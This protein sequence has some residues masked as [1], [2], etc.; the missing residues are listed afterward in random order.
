M[1]GAPLGLVGAEEAVAAAD[2]VDADAG[3][4]FGEPPPVDADEPVAGAEEADGGAL[5]APLPSAVALV[6]FAGFCPVLMRGGPSS[7][8]TIEGLD[9]ARASVMRSGGGGAGRTAGA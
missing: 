6:P 4:L 7:G 5:A 1:L 9:L 8:S 2:E 3:A